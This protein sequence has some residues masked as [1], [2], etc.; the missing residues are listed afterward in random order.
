MSNQS[1]TFSKMSLQ[2]FMR[3]PLSGDF[4]AWLNNESNF[5]SEAITKAA[6]Q[7]YTRQLFSGTTERTH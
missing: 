3:Q 1:N 4:L 7:E 5:M 6:V 2:H